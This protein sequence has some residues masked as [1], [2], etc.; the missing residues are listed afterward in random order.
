MV[1]FLALS[2]FIP[3]PE[4]WHNTILSFIHLVGK[5]TLLNDSFYL[6]LS[7][8]MF[9]FKISL[10]LSQPQDKDSHVPAT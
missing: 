6:R 4:V 3:D 10:F 9:Y 5:N 2:D 1:S 8:G 7:F